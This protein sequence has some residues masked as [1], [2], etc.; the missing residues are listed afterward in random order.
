M[1]HPYLGKLLKDCI[2]FNHVHQGDIGFE[3]EVEGTSLPTDG[4]PGGWTV[5]AENSLRG[6][7]EYISHRPVQAQ[8][9]DKHLQAICTKLTTSPIVVK[10]S[11]RCSTH[12]HLN[13]Q[14]ETWE[15]AVNSIII[16]ACIE[17]LLIQLCGNERNGNLFCLP[18]YD[19]GDL[20]LYM[21]HL[22]RCLS[23]GHWG[24]GG[25][26][27]YAA[28][29]IDPLDS[30]GSIEC[31]CFPLSIDPE[32]LESWAR[33]LLKIR[34]LARHT[35]DP[36]GY[37]HWSYKNPESMAKALFGDPIMNV[38][39]KDLVYLGLE[40]A[41][42]VYRSCHKLFEYEE[43]KKQKPKQTLEDAY[44]EGLDH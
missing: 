22:S 17:P 36:E 28:F 10:P 5:K 6:G 24:F 31:R 2:P 1:K 20:P 40:T 16:S 23:L 34:D 11:A 19:T 43:T 42:E 33:Y 26:G 13:F 15:T 21:K 18:N 3:L 30:L 29:N 41:F 27:K 8:K 12:I 4:T 39:N 32:E 25:R 35:F 7:Y 44:F 9:L 14:R 38:F 37:I